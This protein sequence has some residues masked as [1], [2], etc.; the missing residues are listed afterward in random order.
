MIYVFLGMQGS[1]KGTQA[2]FLSQHL[3]LEHV[4]LGEYFRTEMSSNTPLGVTAKQYISKGFLV[5]DEE[6][7]GV[8]N[9]IFMGMG[10]GFIFDGF[11]RT[12]PQAWY[13]SNLYPINKVIYLE[14]DDNIA[15][16]RM[17][18]RRICND[19]KKDYNLLINPPKASSKCDICSG[20]II[21]R[22][23]DTDELIQN[24]LDLFHNET[25]PLTDY[26]E[27][28]NLL[29]VI[30]AVGDINDIFENIKNEIKV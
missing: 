11:P 5:P 21:K 9:K 27:K 26:Y 12:L 13:L 23:D 25:K 29:T 10:K 3:G 8:I 1:G 30:N 14:L 28:A 24:R 19:C 4:S 7:F 20:K 22:A 18:A 6:V 15:R 16:E 2:K 17:M